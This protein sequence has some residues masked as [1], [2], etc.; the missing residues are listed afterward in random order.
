M[1]IAEIPAWNPTSLTGL[2]VSATAFGVLGICLLLAGFKLF[3]WITPK[4]DV[5][6]ELAENKNMAV[7]IVVASLILGVSI[8]LSRVIG[9]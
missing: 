6:R 5:Q 1:I 3:D 4:I 2:M 9:A 7:A 8:L